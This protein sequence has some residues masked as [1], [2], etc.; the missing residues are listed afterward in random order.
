MKREYLDSRF[1]QN[2]AGVRNVAR[3]YQAFIPHQKRPLKPQ[4]PRNGSQPFN[5][6]R[7]GYQLR[8]RAKLEHAHRFY[9]VPIANN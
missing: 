2:P 9:F 8:P 1:F 5:R 3:G 4:L 7:P 6:P